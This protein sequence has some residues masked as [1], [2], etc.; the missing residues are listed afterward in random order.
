M[1]RRTALAALP[2]AL[3]A[4]AGTVLPA[5]AAAP[6]FSTAALSGAAEVPGPGDPDGSGFARVL[7]KPNQSEVCTFIIY[8]GIATPTGAHIHEGGPDVAGPIVVDFTPL[9]GTSPVNVVRGC[10]TTTPEL[11]ADIAANPE[12]YYVNVHNGIYPAGAIRGQLG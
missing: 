5:A 2:L 4:V 8:R 12:E 6:G 11:A 3:L 9:I 7:A 10:T 1:R